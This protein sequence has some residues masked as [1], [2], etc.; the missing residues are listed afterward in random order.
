MNSYE[1]SLDKKAKE[2]EW[3]RDKCDKY[4]YMIALFCGMAAGIIDALFVRVPGQ[5][6]L[7][8]LTD[9]GTDDFVKKIANILWRGDERRR[10]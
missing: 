6:Q 8:K 5:G 2:I 7:S 4:D 1:L 9:K 10:L 3:S